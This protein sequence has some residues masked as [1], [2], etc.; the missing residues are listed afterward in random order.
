MT[1]NPLIVKELE[2]AGYDKMMTSLPG[3]DQLTEEGT[4]FSNPVDGVDKKMPY[5]ANFLKSKEAVETSRRIETNEKVTRRNED[6]KYLTDEAFQS[7][8]GMTKEEW[9][10]GDKAALVKGQA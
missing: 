2:K 10:T 3:S 1:R 6:A 4:P 7:R 5:I 9:N 8:F